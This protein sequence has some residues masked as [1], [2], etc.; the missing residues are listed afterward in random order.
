M[1]STTSLS[2][3]SR[4]S[5]PEALVSFVRR[6][7]ADDGEPVSAGD[8]PLVD[9]GPR[10]EDRSRDDG[11]PTLAPAGDPR[12]AIPVCS[13]RCERC[14]TPEPIDRATCDGPCARWIGEECYIIYGS[15]EVYCLDC[16]PPPPAP[17][18]PPPAVDGD[19]GGPA[20]IVARQGQMIEEYHRDS[21]AMGTT[22]VG[23]SGDA[24]LWTFA[25]VRS[26]AL[27]PFLVRKKDIE[28]EV[29]NQRLISDSRLTNLL[30]VD[31]PSTRL[32][33]A[34]AMSRIEENSE[35]DSYIGRGGL[36]FCF[37]HLPFDD[38]L[39]ELF[40]GTSVTRG[41]FCVMP[42]LQERVED[43]LRLENAVLKERRRTREERN[44]N[45]PPEGGKDA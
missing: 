19:G 15:D 33:S 23:H 39:G 40:I 24:H 30:F 11:L 3:C 2:W 34:G 28:G 44:L 4:M 14:G 41:G 31:P 29:T 16:R 42:A 7:R 12:S 36:E 6:K 38:K 21:G 32:A 27:A 1:P 35:M 17:T 5:S 9:R 25:N 13:L 43:E 37:Y 20:E 22:H 26:R 45:R 10:P 8:G 18:R